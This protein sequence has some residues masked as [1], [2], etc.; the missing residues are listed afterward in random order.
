M[1]EKIPTFNALYKVGYFRTMYWRWW[2]FPK[3][4]ATKTS[5]ALFEPFK[6]GLFWLDQGLKKETQAAMKSGKKYK[7]ETII[8]TTYKPAN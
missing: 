6:M 7:P 8:D 3:I 2:Q 5:E 1:D 4:P